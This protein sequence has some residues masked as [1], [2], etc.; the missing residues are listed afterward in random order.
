MLSNSLGQRM[1]RIQAVIVFCF[2]VTAFVGMISVRLLSGLITNV[3]GT[4]PAQIAAM[5]DAADLLAENRIAEAYLILSHG[6]AGTDLIKMRPQQM[7][8][9]LEE[10]RMLTRGSAFA[11]DVGRMRV[12]WTDYLRAQARL[13]SL[14]AQHRYPEAEAAFAGEVEQ[15]FATLD[16][17]IDDTIGEILSDTDGRERMARRLSWWTTMVMSLSC[18]ASL[19]AALVL[20]RIGR[21]RLSEPLAG[22]T[23]AVGRLADGDLDIEISGG[24]RPDEIG[25]MARALEVFRANSKRLDDAQR[26][27]LAA[28]AEAEALARHDALTGLPN[29]RLFVEAID[30][31]VVARPEKRAALLMIDLDRFKPVNDLYGHQIGDR[32][33]CALADRIE[34]LRLDLTFARLGGDEFA[35]LVPLE[36]GSDNAVRASEIIL[37]RISEPFELDGASIQIGGTIGISVFP[38]DGQ[39]A[40]SLLRAADLAMYQA[41]VKDKGS[42][43]FYETGMQAEVERRARFDAELQHAIEHGEIMP[44]YQPLVSI[45]DSALVGIE[46][47]ARWIHTTRGVIMPDEFI[48]AADERGLLPSLTYSILRQACVDAASWPDHL[49]LSINLAPSQ[50]RDPLLAVRLLGILREARIRPD[51][52]EVEVTENTLIGDLEATKNVLTSLQNLG[53]TIALDDFG[54]GYSSLYHLRELHFD[55]IKVDRSFVQ[56]L[57]E[58]DEKGKIV[59]AMIGLGKSLGLTTTAEGI[60][61][62]EQ[63]SRL[64]EWGCDYGQGYFFGRPMTGAAADELLDT[65]RCDSARRRSVGASG[66][67]RC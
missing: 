10:L 47:L 66:G 45:D 61:D 25:A 9:R 41:K 30:R 39:D 37:Q 26:A 8:Q 36:L 63:W 67:R 48:P 7:Q 50:L 46:L 2:L 4:V 24:N 1:Y 15:R 28:Q 5:S 23:E 40:S 19:L 42:F 21:K 49:R 34:A 51:R 60:E 44:Y 53:M 27:T 35:A 58:G 65:L 16:R 17:M 56:A 55:K 38:D 22:I 29:R 3:S 54:T 32:V 31:L 64:A 52:I 18:A 33:L 62:A 57:D 59:R 14:V 12:A 20:T 11:G 6:R 43:R 13:R